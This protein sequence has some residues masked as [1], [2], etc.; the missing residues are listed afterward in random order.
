MGLQREPKH[1]VEVS[2]RLMSV[3]ML[4]STVILLD[5]VRESGSY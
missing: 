3:Q 5:G 4:V 2:L 1:V